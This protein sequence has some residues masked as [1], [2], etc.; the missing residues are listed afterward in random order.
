M[1]AKFAVGD[2][3]RHTGKFLRSVGWYTEVPINGRIISV[4]PLGT[5]VLYLV[6]W[7]DG[8]E[9]KIIEPNIETCPRAQNAPKE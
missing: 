9:T 4:Q 8:S 3:V 6:E 7:S 5:I 1:K 2:I